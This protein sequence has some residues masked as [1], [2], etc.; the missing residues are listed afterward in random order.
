MKY[1]PFKRNLGLLLLVAFAA[2]VAFPAQAQDYP[3]KNWKVSAFS[4]TGES[5]VSIKLPKSK[6]STNQSVGSGVIIDERGF[7]VT[8]RHVVGSY[9]TVTVFLSDQTELVA[10]VI[11]ADADNDLAILRVKTEKQLKALTLGPVADLMVGEEV[12]AVGHPYGYTNTVSTGIISALNRRI[13]M[14]TGEVLTGLIQTNADINPGNS[15]GPL[16]NVNGELIGINVAI[17]DGAQG[18]AFA[19]NAGTV[20]NV[21]AKNLSS[22]KIAGVGHGIYCQE[23]VVAET[24]DRQRA[25]VAGIYKQ[26]P[27]AVSGLQQGDQILQVNQLQVA[28]RFDLERYLWDKQ[29]GQQVQLKVSREGKTMTVTMTLASASQGYQ[30][31]ALDMAPPVGSAVGS[32]GT[33][34]QFKE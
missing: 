2:G 34:T 13:T 3:R 12:L 17:R 14:P 11:L 24:G 10:Q 29:P 4:K 18:I 25:V 6:Y 19:I 31:A 33:P 1:L 27:A 23:A 15:G 9:E 21:L 5:V 28:N 8:N 26:S 32:Y 20:R 16:V 30:A 7:I 22:W